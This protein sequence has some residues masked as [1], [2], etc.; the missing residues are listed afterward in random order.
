MAV[1]TSKHPLHVHLF[2]VQG[3][4][5]APALQEVLTKISALPLKDRLKNKG[6][7]PIR[8]ES[9]VS[10]T[11]GG[12]LWKLDF[13]RLRS[14]GPGRASNTQQATSFDLADGERFA[15]ETAALYD[16]GSGF[17][18]L[19]Y[20]H[21]GPRAGGIAD[22]LS[23]FVKQGEGYDLLIQLDPSA[24]ARFKNKTIFSRFAFRVAP[25][26][27]SQSWR[28]KNVAML[29]AINMQQKSFGADW[30]EVVVSMEAGSS[31]TLKIKDKLKAILG[32]ANEASDAVTELKASGRTAAGESL[33][34]VNLLTEKLEEVYKKVPL[35]DGR[36]LEQAARWGRLQDAYDK[37]K[38]AKVIP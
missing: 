23:L 1:M 28:N 20:N 15:E 34:E 3:T 14:E 2:K 36:R 32:L 21:Y 33:D 37:W 7:S 22:Y 13:C 11:T 6:W 9:V 4:D 30:V 35:D 19:Q 27:L 18:V 12:T 29:D 25:A 31:G 5:N 24:Q 17:M 8:L 16:E 38:A 26:R 10:P